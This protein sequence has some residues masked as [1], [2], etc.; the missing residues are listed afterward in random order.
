M[1]A[2]YTDGHRSNRLPGLLNHPTR[3]MAGCSEWMLLASNCCESR[4]RINWMHTHEPLKVRHIPHAFC[5]L[6]LFDACSTARALFS[7]SERQ[8]GFVCSS[9]NAVIHAESFEDLLQ[10]QND[11][12][13]LAFIK[14][15][16]DA[17]SQPPLPPRNLVALFAEQ[18]NCLSRWI[19]GCYTNSHSP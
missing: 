16:S 1:Q 3:Q 10:E 13:L 11:Q 8:A 9:D 17:V 6:H 5:N 18:Q 2:R 7:R 4:K 19:Q 12:K 14:S 15:C